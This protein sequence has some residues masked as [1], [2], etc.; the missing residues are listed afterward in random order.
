MALAVES[1]LLGMSNLGQSVF[2]SLSKDRF[3][4]P[5][6]CQK[7]IDTF[8]NKIIGEGKNATTLQIR[9]ADTE[10]QKQLK[11]YTAEKRQFKTQEYNEAVYGPNSPYRFY[12]PISGTFPSPTQ[13]RSNATYINQSTPASSLSST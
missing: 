2:S 8:N 9:Y 7:I 1:A 11:T 6:I 13:V 12:S 10:P 4:S 3:E 5:E